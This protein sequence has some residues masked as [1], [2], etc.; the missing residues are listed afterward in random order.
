MCSRT[1]QVGVLGRGAFGLAML[2]EDPSSSRKVV[3]KCMRIDATID[4]IALKRMQEEDCGG[5]V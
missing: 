5:Q 2:L 1:P 3:A 4:D